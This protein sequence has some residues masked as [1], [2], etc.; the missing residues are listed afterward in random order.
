MDPVFRPPEGALAAL[1]CYSVNLAPGQ[2][3]FVPSGCP[4]R[5][6]AVIGFIHSFCRV[7]NTEDSI[8]VS[9]NFVN[10]TNIAEA[11]KHL[12]IAALQVQN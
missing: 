3:L 12:R 4:H 10:E 9:G 2:L 8:A 1:P 5:C 11:E 7:E 6:W